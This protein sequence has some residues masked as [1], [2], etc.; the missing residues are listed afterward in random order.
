MNDLRLLKKIKQ[1]EAACLRN[2][3]LQSQ[4][5]PVEELPRIKRADLEQGDVYFRTTRLTPQSYILARIIIQGDDKNERNLPYHWYLLERKVPELSGVP[6]YQEWLS[7]G[8][9]VNI[10]YYFNEPECAFDITYERDF[11]ARIYDSLNNVKRFMQQNP[12]TDS[13]IAVHLQGSFGMRHRDTTEDITDFLISVIKEQADFYLLHFLPGLVGIP[14]PTKRQ[15]VESFFH[16]LR[17]A[18]TELALANVIEKAKAPQ[19][20]EA[21]VWKE[22]RDRKKIEEIARGTKKDLSDLAEKILKEK[23]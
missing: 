13:N 14:S 3:H 7:E 4:G 20:Y 5:K 19:S 10:K 12:P 17:D 11:W 8:S 23:F 15:K 6:D 2:Y 1:L 22:I 18:P 21:A 9:K 16:A